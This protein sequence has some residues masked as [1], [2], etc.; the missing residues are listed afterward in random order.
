MTSNDSSFYADLLQ[1]L[2]VD[3]MVVNAN[4]EVSPSRMMCQERC[5]VLFLREI[6]MS[7]KSAHLMHPGRV[8]T[9]LRL[10]NKFK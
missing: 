3:V 6:E 7:K 1:S 10:V 5:F 8:D 9:I 2:K 4:R